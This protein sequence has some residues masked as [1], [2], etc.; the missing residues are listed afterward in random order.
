M[1]QALGVKLLLLSAVLLLSLLPGC[2]APE[3]AVLETRFLYNS[4]TSAYFWEAGD[5]VLINPDQPYFVDK[6]S[7]I[8]RPLVLDPLERM[9]VREY[10]GVG[11]NGN[12]KLLAV[13]ANKAYILEAD[14]SRIWQIDGA[15]FTL[16]CV[17]L[18]NFSK[19]T[20]AKAGSATEGSG[21]ATLR[22]YLFPG[23]GESS[24]APGTA[25]AGGYFDNDTAGSMLPSVVISFFVCGNNLYTL[26]RNQ[27]CRRPLGNNTT[28]VVLADDLGNS[29]Y[30]SCDGEYLYY[31]D[32][33]GI[34]RRLPLA[35]GEAST[36]LDARA[37]YLYVS[38]DAVYYT[39]ISDNG[40]YRFDKA[41][42]HSQRLAD[43][44]DFGIQVSGQD[45]YYLGTDD[46]L[47]RISTT[48]GQSQQVSSE[49]MAEFYVDAVSNSIYYLSLE[50]DP[51]TGLEIYYRIDTGGQKQKLVL[52]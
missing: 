21:A 24:T 12:S 11:T 37:K 30:Y 27:I 4:A 38:T 2:K 44:P 8:V 7:G 41:S 46:K 22:Q 39:D 40:L 5:Y 47:R 48:G 28:P 9:Y 26:E 29:S 33:H 35:G 18:T 10:Q 16:D 25:G 23:N 43:S 32:R 19:V 13:A 15:S 17:D 3:A 20:V 49:K 34:I 51:E 45:L 6:S 31:I 14:Y 50:Q 1:R 42:G 52:P 36:L